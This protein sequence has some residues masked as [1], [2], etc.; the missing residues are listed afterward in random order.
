[1]EQHALYVFLYSYSKA[2][3]FSVPL[4][5]EPPVTGRFPPQWARSAE[6][7]II[8]A[9][10]LQTAEHT[11]KLPVIWDA[12]S[13]V[14]PAPMVNA[15]AENGIMCQIQASGLIRYLTTSCKI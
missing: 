1:M 4:W 3:Y 11:L 14:S 12:M 13:I 2:F 8:F 6:F 15:C 10:N 5:G 9:V 7:D